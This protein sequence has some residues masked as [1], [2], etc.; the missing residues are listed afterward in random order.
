MD[1]DTLLAHRAQFGTEPNPT[2]A[3]QPHLTE[4]EQEVYR[5]LIEDRFG[6][7]VRLEQERIRFSYVS[8]ALRPWER[9]EPDSGLRQRESR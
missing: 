5:D 4:T 1:H 6:H 8:R 3:P 2:A 9:H 7:A